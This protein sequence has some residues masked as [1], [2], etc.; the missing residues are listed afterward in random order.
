VLMV[1]GID[2]LVAAYFDPERPFAGDSFDLLG[3]NP[4]DLITFDDLLATSLLDISWRP[5]AIRVLIAE[6][7]HVA[8]DLAAIPSDLDLWAADSATLAATTTL[9]EWLDKLHGVGPTIASKL[10]ARKRPRLVPV[11]DDVVQRAIA[12]P[13]GQFWVTLAEALTEPALRDEIEALRPVGADSISLLRLLDIA[14]W[15]RHSRSR[16][17]RY[18]RG[19][20]GVPEPGP[21]PS[22]T[23]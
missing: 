2:A 3:D 23:P 13:K 21:L 17:A 10:M 20:A 1:A 12:P 19:A 4:P 22:P 14:I 7:A 8:V 18:A 11:H 9:H 5:Q 15:M 6:T 16:N